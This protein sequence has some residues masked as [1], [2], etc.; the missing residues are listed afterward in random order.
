MLTP[1]RTLLDEHFRFMGRTKFYESIDEMQVD[2]DTP[3]YRPFTV[4]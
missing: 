4:A 1:H 3:I 2:L